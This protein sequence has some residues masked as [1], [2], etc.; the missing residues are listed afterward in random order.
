MC[1]CGIQYDELIEVEGSR[2]IRKSNPSI[3]DGDNSNWKA[4]N[5][6]FEHVSLF[7]GRFHGEDTGRD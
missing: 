2:Q 3:T 1:L 6:I 4:E 7:G 5:H